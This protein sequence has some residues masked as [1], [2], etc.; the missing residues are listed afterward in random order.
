MPDFL[1]EVSPA[2]KLAMQQVLSPVSKGWSTGNDNMYNTLPSGAVS[3]APSTKGCGTQSTCQ[4]P[5]SDGSGGM[6]AYSCNRGFYGRSVGF[7]FSTDSQ[8]I[9]QSGSGSGVPDQSERTHLGQMGIP[10]TFEDM[11]NK[12]KH[13]RNVH[14]ANGSNSW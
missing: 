10:V 2:R 5:I 4:Q 6:S 12:V 11:T 14:Y 7:D 3:T 1:F 13:G 9:R 8:R